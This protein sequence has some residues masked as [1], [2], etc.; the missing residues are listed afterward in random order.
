MA[1]TLEDLLSRPVETLP[2]PPCSKV[3]NFLLKTDAPLTSLHLD[4][5]VTHRH[6]PFA[7]RVLNPGIGS[8]NLSSILCQHLSSATPLET[9]FDVFLFACVL[10]QTNSPVY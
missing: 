7:I 2:L 10:F 9:D 6:F 3:I 5:A 1:G 8:P 4:S